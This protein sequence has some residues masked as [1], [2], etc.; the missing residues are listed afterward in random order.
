MKKRIERVKRVI[1]LVLLILFL[2]LVSGEGPAPQERVY[3]LALT[4]G[5]YD[6][7]FLTWELEALF[8]K[9]AYGLL[10]PQRFLTEEERALLVLDYLDDVRDT[11]TLSAEIERLY[12][13][14]QVNNPGAVTAEAR[15]ELE[16]LR[17]R[18][19]VQAPVAE[20]IL[21]EQVSVVLQDAGL[22]LLRQVFPP[23]SG[24]ITPLPH[25]LIVSPRE[26]I[27]TIYQRQLVTGLHAAQK[28]ALEEAIEEQVPEVSAYVTGI[29]GLA[30][31]PAML[32][33]S[34]SIDHLAD[35]MAHEWTHHYLLPS[36]VGW[37]Y[38]SSPEIRTINETSASLLGEWAGQEL[39]RRFYEPLLAREKP[40][41]DPLQGER[42]EEQ[43]E[44]RF[45]FVAE[46]R[47][48][49]V[50]VDALLASERVG[51]AETYMEARRRL[52][53]EH[54]Y[55][56]RR[57]NQAYFAFHGSYAAR[58]GGGSAGEDPL[59]PAVR[60]V[61]SL[62]ETPRDF[63][64]HIAGATSLEELQEIITALASRA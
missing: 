37:G 10:A 54:G 48:T 28:T 20:A 16:D 36:P 58:P 63:L 64:R 60:L 26:E 51:E 57:L 25:I 46:M 44:E 32:L 61:W 38:L 5:G 40:L 14:P 42:E 6:F 39:V 2:L 41:P 12:T 17:A 55:R 43:L 59:G 4:S 15:A 3:R 8:R 34:S 47:E 62:S 53:V 33:E 1:S 49:R 29:G 27:E 13:D 21:G 24:T 7:N 19:E 11:R 23:V 35:V 45:D 31:Y 18:L 30:T 9:L 56:L 52:F 22:G 50:T